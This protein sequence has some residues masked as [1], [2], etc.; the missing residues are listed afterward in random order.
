MRRS[1]CP[2]LAV[3]RAARLRWLLVCALLL[4]SVAPGCASSRYAELRRTPDTPLVERLQ[5]TARGGPR[6]S[7]RTLQTLRRWDLLPL[8]E[9]DSESA[10]ETL[11]AITAREPTPEGYHAAAELA[12]IE[13]KKRTRSDPQDALD[14]QALAVANAYLYLFD[15]RVGFLRNPYDPQFRGACD[16]YN[17]ALEEML[18]LIAPE[19]GLQPGHTH[20]AETCRQRLEM[21]VVAPAPCGWRADQFERFEFVSDYELRGLNNKYRTFG[22]GVPLIAVRKAQASDDM[23]EAF[24]PPDLSVPMTVFLRV[25]GTDPRAVTTAAAAPAVQR[26]RLEIYDPLATTDIDVAGVRVPLESD[27][28]T[29]LAYFLDNPKLHLINTAGLLRP[30]KYQNLR[31][32]YMLQPYEPGKIPVIMVHGLWS[33]PVTWMEMFNDLRGD[34]LLRSQYQFWFYL[35]PTGQPFPLSAA[36]LRSDLA[37]ARAALDPQ[38]QVRAWDQTVL[39][40][41]SMGGLVAKMQAVE[42]GEGFWQTVSD[43]PIQLVKADGPL[44]EQLETTFFFQP[45]SS[46]RRVIT[47]GTPHRG[48][49]FANRLT[50]WLARRFIT[51]PHVMVAGTQELLTQNPEAS[52]RLSLAE[53]PTSIDSLAPESPFLPALLDAPRPPWVKYHNVVGVVPPDGWLARFVEEGDGIVP[54]RSAHLDDVSSELVVPADH[55]TVHAHP[56]SVLEVRRILL[57]HLAELR[58]GSPPPLPQVWPVMHQVPPVGPPVGYA[59]L[60]PAPAP[61]ANQ[62]PLR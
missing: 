44:R 35:Y 61:V 25:V 36:Q 22:L 47:I 27:I 10:L 38:R 45:N 28:S 5:L 11:L 12:Y 13:G 33:S 40:G 6:P 56:R 9:R 48:S 14:H 30:D 53:V 32:L 54:Y 26:A 4:A 51:L 3:A 7:E 34:P 15:P 2:T 58:T 23:A 41:H 17:G 43:T 1:T 21:S 39:V 37:Q 24:Y 50:R 8:W 55:T 19:S 20:V 52:L 49:Y 62:I 29:P 16:L 18:R 60:V 57:E 42:G 46:V 31:G 59:P